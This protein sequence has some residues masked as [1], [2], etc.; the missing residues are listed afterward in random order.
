MQIVLTFFAGA[1][2]LERGVVR[3]GF[4]TQ[5]KSKEVEVEQE[6]TGKGTVNAKLS[7]R[8]V[9]KEQ[10]LRDVCLHKRR[11]TQRRTQLE[12]QLS[13]EQDADS[14]SRHVGRVK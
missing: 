10:G 13:P 7:S 1:Q 5:L 9:M 14:R 3:N 11:Y 8:A 12:R 4:L 6:I 2:H